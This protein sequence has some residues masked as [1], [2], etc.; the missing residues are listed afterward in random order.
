MSSNVRAYNKASL[1][2]LLLFTFVFSA[3]NLHADYKWNLPPGLPEPVIPQSNPMSVAKVE[4]GRHLFYYKKLSLNG[5]MACATCHRQ[6][7]A[8]TDGRVTAQGTT[9]EIHPRNTPSLGNVAYQPVLTWAQPKLTRLEEQL[10]IPLLGT[11]PVELGMAG[12]KKIIVRRLKR[13]P[14]YHSMFQAAFGDNKAV[15]LE[16]MAKALASFQ[17]RLITANSAYDRED[18]SLAAERGAKL[19]FG[20][21]L[22]CFRCHP[23]PFFTD[24][25]THVGLGFKEIAFHNTGL[26]N[27]AG[28]G[29][30]PPKNTGLHAHTGQ[31]EDMGRF[32]TPSLRNVAVTAPYMHDGS[33]PTLAQVIDIYAAGGRGP[34][35]SNPHKSVFVSGFN[36]TSIEKSDL[37]AFLTSLTDETFL[38]DPRFSDPF[39]NPLK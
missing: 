20:E 28:K 7:R 25:L 32:R 27:L 12:K 10:L 29:A 34:G 8:F 5:K 23:A 15:S 38:T 21:R 18:L 6:A 37:I 11:Q 30:Y 39:T 26:Y 33:V 22:N 24:S 19:F 4:L 2:L 16:N 9:G 36:L 35:R 3:G 17:R 1:F 13:D 14:A 31:P